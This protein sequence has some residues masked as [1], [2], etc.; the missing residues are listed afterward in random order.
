LAGISVDSAEV[1]AK[2]FRHDRR[3][4]LVDA[5][6]R[7]LTLHEFPQLSRLQPELNGDGI[8]IVSMDTEQENLL[9]PFDTPPKG[10]QKVVIWNAEVEATALS[11]IIDTWFSD[12]LGT[13]VKLVHMP[14]KSLRP[15]DTTSGFRPPG[16]YVSFADA[17]PFMMMGEA[18]I[19]DLNERYEG[20]QKFTIHRF[21]PNIVFS[22]GRPNQEDEI[23]NFKINGV[24]FTG[25]ENCARC[26]I[27]NVNP[28]TG[29]VDENTEPLATL[30]KYRLQNRKINFGRNVV[31]SGTGT[32]RVG[33]RIELEQ[34]IEKDT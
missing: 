11:D 24:S 28:E 17:Y 18:S 16:K 10:Q 32:V 12:F 22:G 23:E 19:S 9:I 25:L 30:S 1:E 27:P 7:F 2:G 34:H 8:T 13:P 6:N 4:M 20:N 26:T 14:K 31:H 3:F 33:N 5:N 29:K 15:V 21:R